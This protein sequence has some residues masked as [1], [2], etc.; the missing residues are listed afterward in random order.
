MLRFIQSRETVMNKRIIATL[1]GLLVLFTIHAL[2]AETINQIEV[3]GKG[4][5]SEQPNMATTRFS[6]SQRA[7]KAEQGKVIVDTQMTNLLKLCTKLGIAKKDI[8]AAQLT[9]YPEYD[10]KRNR[11]LIGYQVRREVQIR[12]RDLSNYPA[13]LDGAVGIGATHSGSL[14]LDFSNRD[15]LEQKA[16]I[17][18]FAQAKQKASLLAKQAGGKLGRAIWISETGNAPP[19]PVALGARQ[20]FADTSNYNTGEVEVVKYL[21]VRFEFT[22]N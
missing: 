3:N 10:Y 11:K 1:S 8:Q 18:A 20:E 4:V 19:M 6:F 15:E 9:V 21:L 14:S 22:S 5:I 2:R 7:M 16:L 12:V 17:N 13:L